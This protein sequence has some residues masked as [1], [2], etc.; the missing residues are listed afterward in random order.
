MLY[1][2][3]PSD[4]TESQIAFLEALSCDLLLDMERERRV[5]TEWIRDSSS[6]RRCELLRN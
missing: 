6:I 4:R 3:H 5:V 1:P 2:C